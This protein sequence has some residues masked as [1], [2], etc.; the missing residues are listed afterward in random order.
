M[1]V[2]VTMSDSLTAALARLPHAVSRPVQVAALKAGAEP[3]R[4]AAAD[5]APRDEAAGAPHLADN[6]IVAVATER[7]LEATG[8]ET[9]F[10]EVGPRREFFYGF[11]QEFGHGP[12]PAQPFMRP[13]FDSNI[14]TSLAIVQAHLWA[15]IQSGTGR[16]TSTGG[17]LL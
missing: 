10:V 9:P 13:A 4:Q 14:R 11:F 7:Q 12:G 1:K 2:G 15:A 8:N 5:H 17:G 6:I 3:M 16:A